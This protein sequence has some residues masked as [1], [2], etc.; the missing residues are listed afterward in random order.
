MLASLRKYKSS[1][2]VKIFVVLIAIPFV[3]WGMGPLFTG[4]NLN[5]IVQIGK[6]KIPTKEFVDFVKYNIE[7]EETWEDK[8]LIDRMLS[9]FIGEKLINKEIED[10][11]IIVS[12]NS[13][14]SIIKNEK[15]F[16]K[17]NKFSRT[18]YEKFLIK[19]NL[20]AVG[21]EANILRQEKKRQL[22]DFI[23]G[24]LM[25][26]N[27]FVNIAYDKINQKRNI[28]VINLNDVIKKKTGFY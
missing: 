16:K 10:L 15:I 24:G 20:S 6:E 23:G 17:E 27:F 19:N 11:K 28:E 18:E 26:A 4:G 7:K 14:S 12:N 9:N 1:I 13:L 5:T 25:P 22:F 21:L 3:F 8:G 2:F